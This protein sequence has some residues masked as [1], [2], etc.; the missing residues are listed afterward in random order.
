M[1]LPMVMVCILCL[2]W[3]MLP[4][5]LGLPSVAAGASLAD[6]EPGGGERSIEVG[7]LQLLEERGIPS[8]MGWD[9]A[10]AVLQRECGDDPRYT[11][12][13]AASRCEWCK[14]SEAGGCGSWGDTLCRQRP[15]IVCAAK[16][17]AQARGLGAL[18]PPCRAWHANKAFLH[19]RLACREGMYRRHA[20]R[21]QQLESRL[22]AVEPEAWR[23]V[24]E[25]MMLK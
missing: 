1:L 22:A 3:A 13:P 8:A 19:P 11:A 7:F 21:Q 18:L 9:T 10:E 2:A 12:A 15:E 14:C 5:G 20:E 6:G 24:G 17:G 16:L 25:V 4:G 23:Q